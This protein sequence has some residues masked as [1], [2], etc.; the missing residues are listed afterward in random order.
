MNQ[1]LLTAFFIATL[2]ATSV[3]Q[4]T[5][6]K[7][8]NLTALSLA[9]SWVQ[10][11]APTSAD[12]LLFNSTWGTAGSVPLGGDLSV[13]GIEISNIS[14]TGGR[15]TT[16]S[17]QTLTLGSGG[18]NM[19]SA[20]NSF[21][22]DPAIILSADQTWSVASGRILNLVAAGMT[23][24]FTATVGG[25]G[26]LGFD[27]SGT[28]SYGT[29]LEVN[30]AILRVNFAT[31]DVSFSNPNNS[32]TSLTVFNGTARFASIAAAGVDSAAGVFTNAQLGGNGTHG[33]FVYTGNTA[34]T[35]RG[36][37]VDRRSASSGILVSTAGQA[38]TVGGNIT[39]NLGNSTGA[40]NNAFRVGGEGNLVLNG[41]ISNNVS[42]TN[43]TSLAKEGSGTL[44]LGGANVFAGGVSA[45]AGSV[46]VNNVAGSG[47]GTGAVTVA[48]GAAL[49]GSGTISGA[50]T[51]SGSLR[52]G[53]S[54]GT[55]TV[56]N[57]VTWNGGDAWVFELGT[58]APT[59]A[60]AI[61]GGSTQDK[62]AI[63]GAGS[64]F[65]KGSGTSWTFDFAG[66][67]SEGF[68]Q[69]ST[70]TGVETFAPGDFT[71]TNLGGGNTGEFTIQD[72][73]LYLEVVPE[74]STYA[75]L[76]LAVLG[77]GAHVIRRRHTRRA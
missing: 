7:S 62:L 74:P 47:T 36:F 61:A 46:L 66:T 45:A 42:G 4:Q 65:L 54:I 33:L 5:L 43:N 28:N 76:G 51:I 30:T 32:F 60:G 49:G 3:A 26:T 59:L 1:N 37:T 63:T 20:A 6:T 21:R 67:G 57:D 16:T 13:N 24:D 69:L 8:N 14:G 70:W 11:V 18:I 27:A 2:A 44:T 29:Q 68:Y 15:I 72:N 35:D 19:S 71:A 17:G 12:T 22:I 73:A 52:P 23:G 25:A 56:G 41:I 38:L 77:L 39:H 31:T 58:A 10:N 34:S 53:N 9:G 50:T 64:D 75:L 55:L 48:S 40:V